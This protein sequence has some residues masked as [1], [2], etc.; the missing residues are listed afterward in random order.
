MSVHL[1][2]F[3]QVKM[4][5]CIC[6]VFKRPE[7]SSTMKQI[8][9]IYHIIKHKI[10][11]LCCSFISHKFV[12]YL[13]I[14]NC[15]ILYKLFFLMTSLKSLFNSQIVIL[16]LLESKKGIWTVECPIWGTFIIVLW[17]NSLNL[18]EHNYRDSS[19]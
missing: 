6:L 2:D 9:C 12:Y 11:K 16:L 14:S 17:S 18:W 8:S 15:F 19:G 1:F 10:K 4:N 7:P 5:S 3:S 13:F